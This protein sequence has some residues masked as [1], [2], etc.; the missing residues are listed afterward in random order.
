MIFPYHFSVFNFYCYSITVVPIFPPLPSSAYPIPHSH[1]LPHTVVHVHE[2]FVHVL[3]LS[4]LFLSFTPLPP[5]PLPLCPLSVCSIIPGPG[6][7]LFVSLFCSLDSCYTEII[8][9]LFFIDWL[10]SF[11]IIS[12]S[13]HAVAKGRSSFFLSAA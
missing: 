3:C 12:S 10:I 7:I 11:S 13:I 6:S 9:Y 2:S 5:S 4:S 1:V 8:W